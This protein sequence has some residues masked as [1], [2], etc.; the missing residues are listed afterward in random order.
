MLDGIFFISSALKVEQL[1]IFNEEERFE[2]TIETINSIDKFCPSN[3]K[4]IFDAS[5]SVPNEDKINQIVSLGV[6]FF[7]CGQNEQVS[8]M[9]KLGQRSFAET[10]SFIIFLNNIKDRLPR[11]KRIFKISGRYKLNE[12]FVSYQKDFDDSFVYLPTVNSWM[13][14]EKQEE[15]GV[16]RIF[17]LRLWH[18]DYNL[19]DTFQKE[20]YNILNDMVNFNIDVE[21]SYYKNL[22]KYKTFHINPIGL[23]GVLAPTGVVINE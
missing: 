20:L 7:Y 13:T 17:E 15:C 3:K 1:S 10:I 16:D 14:K 19:L 18:M 21:H 23:E 4:Y 6:D 2:Q 8:T 22:S 12:K 11:A 5:H 9:S